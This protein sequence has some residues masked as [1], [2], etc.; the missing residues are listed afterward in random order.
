MT[1]VGSVLIHPAG[2]QVV[3]S[4][5]YTPA[6]C[7]GYAQLTLTLSNPQGKGEEK[8]LQLCDKQYPSVTFEEELRKYGL[9]LTKGL[10]GEQLSFSPDWNTKAIDRWLR[11]L[12]GSL[13]AHLDTVYGV[14]DGTEGRVHWAIL[15]R[16]RKSLFLIDR[17]APSGEDLEEA[18]GT[19]GRDWRFYSARFGMSTIALGV[20]KYHS[21]ITRSTPA[22]TTPKG[23]PRPAHRSCQQTARCRRREGKGHCQRT[24]SRAVCPYLRFRRCH[25]R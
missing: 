23:L 19:H 6:H 4:V 8:S 24:F 3:V 9:Y 13:F 12:T 17:I 21:P 14:R 11:S 18:K 2:L 5:Q 22:H 25:V 20:E 7:E 1:V 10:D 16:E 15:R